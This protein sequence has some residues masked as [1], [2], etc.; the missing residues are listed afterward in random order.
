MLLDVGEYERMMDKLELID[1]I[2]LATR[3]LDEG[4]GID[5]KQVRARLKGRMSA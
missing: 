3:Q 4:K 5:N 2:E 1:D